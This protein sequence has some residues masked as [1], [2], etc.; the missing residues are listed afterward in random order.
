MGYEYYTLNEYK[1][2]FGKIARSSF[3]IDKTV[4]INERE[5]SIIMDDESEKAIVYSAQKPIVKY[6]VMD[7]KEFKV[8]TLTVLDGKIVAVS[9]EINRNCIKI[10]K[11]PRLRFDRP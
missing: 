7:N 11:T 3:G 8:D 10:T 1:K 2:K 5:S 4:L 9:G 6:L